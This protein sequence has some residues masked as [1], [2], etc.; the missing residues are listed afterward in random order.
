MS[1]DGYQAQLPDYEQQYWNTSVAVTLPP[2][3]TNAAKIWDEYLQQY[4][5]GDW[6][7]ALQAINRLVVLEPDQPEHWRIK[8]K[9]HGALGHSICCCLSIDN[10]LNL[11]PDDLDGLR[12]K[13]I[14]HHCHHEYTQALIICSKV[15]HQ[16]P[17]KT[18]FVTLKEAILQA[19]SPRRTVTGA[20]YATKCS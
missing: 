17:G 7:G 4:R 10:L 2:S 15:L 19:M 20:S 16:H 11:L 18:E 12:M 9:L 1:I 3:Q 14:Y 5:N 6:L 13:A 8:A